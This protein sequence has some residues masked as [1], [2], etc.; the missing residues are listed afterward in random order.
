[1]INL[2]DLF[3]LCA[4]IPLDSIPIIRHMCIT[5]SREGGAHRFADGVG[6]GGGL[7]RRGDLPQQ[8]GFLAGS[9]AGEEQKPPVER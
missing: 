6:W 7:K 8:Q 1:L 3:C 5:L 4:K 2:D 9:S